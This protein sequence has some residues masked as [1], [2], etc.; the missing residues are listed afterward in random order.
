M[1]NRLVGT[2]LIILYVNP[3]DKELAVVKKKDF[4]IIND[5]NM[6]IYNRVSYGK[7]R[8]KIED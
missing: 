5:L 6:L 3:L 2:H 1:I 4:K 8:C 7:L